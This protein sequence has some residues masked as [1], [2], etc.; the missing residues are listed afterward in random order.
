[1]TA[2]SRETPAAVGPAAGDV[3]KHRHDKTGPT[4]VVA[5]IRKNGELLLSGP[6]PCRKL[7]TAQP[8]DM[9]VVQT[10][11]TVAARRAAKKAAP[12]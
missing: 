9:M 4:W 8:E 2:V 10:A 11:A 5:S 6:G 12:R 1:M 3:V 7:S